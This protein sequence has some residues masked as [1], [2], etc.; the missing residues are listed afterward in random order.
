MYLSC[1]KRKFVQSQYA[2][3]LALVGSQMQGQVG[4]FERAVKTLYEKEIT[5][6]RTADSHATIWFLV[7]EKQIKEAV[8]ALHAAFLQ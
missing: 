8:N 4:V 6:Y 5:I 2:A 3:K 7:S 1:A